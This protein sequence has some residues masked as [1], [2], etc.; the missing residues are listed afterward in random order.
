MLKPVEKPRIGIIGLSLEL[1]NSAIP[2][3]MNRLREQ[4]GKFE[5]QLTQFTQTSFTRLCYV[6][7]DFI[8][9]ISEAEK[10][11]LEAIVLI[12]MSYT[13]SMMILRP[14]LNTTLPIVI[15]NTQ[16]MLDITNEFCFDNLL[17]NHTSQGTQD[18]TNTLIRSG[19]TFGIESGHYEDKTTLHKLD[20]WLKAAK[21]ARFAKTM[22]VGILGH[23]FQGMGDFGVDETILAAKWGPQLTRLDINR[24]FNLFENVEK[25]ESL[26]LMSADHEQ[27]NI[28]SEVSEEIHL[29][30]SQL[31]SAL[32]H[33]VNENNLDA[34]TMNFLDLIEDKRCVTLPFLG[35]NKL[36][37]DGLGYAG[38]GD[39]LRAAHMAQ[40]RQLCGKANFT[41][42][43]TIDYKNNR[44]LMCHMQECN[45][46]FAR[47][48]KKISLVRK[49]FWVSGIEPYVGMYFTLEPCP[50]TLTTIT[51]DN[52]GNFYYLYYE[53]S[54][55][56]MQPLK[57]LDIPHW[58]VKVDEPI[59]DF[60]TRY[61]NAGGTHHLIA[62]QGH[63]GIALE[64][65]SHLQ[66]FNCIKV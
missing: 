31:E 44:M 16:E 29:K 26:R 38:E 9:A 36:L 55:H 41:E 32:R 58:I 54:I 39:I 42:I 48:D 33:L 11:N 47:K 66:G 6:K 10:Q 2:G 62:V 15:W 7:N 53:T 34:F 37:I 43:Y 17:M 12:P 51:T 52:N 57:G 35:L 24:F 1:Y 63:Q 61:S 45:P 50:V 22:Q 64:K 19:K 27:F 3:Y 65:L 30:S 40:M 25:K 13:A 49:D 18:I 5:T 56:D 4:L 60:L 8:D 20:E 28:S 46:V 59:A 14:V 23:P 21:T